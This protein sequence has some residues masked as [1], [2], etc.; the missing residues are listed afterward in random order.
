MADHFKHQDESFLSKVFKNK[1]S[2]ILL[3]VI[4]IV[5]VYFIFFSSK[6]KNS[7]SDATPPAAPVAPP[8]APPAVPAALAAPEVVPAAPTAVPVQ[9]VILECHLD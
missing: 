1:L 5:G 7:V 2:W 6:N 9:Q 4:V 8:V 3:T